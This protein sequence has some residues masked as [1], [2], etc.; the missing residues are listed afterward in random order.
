MKNKKLGKILLCTTLALATPFAL[1]ACSK[2]A[3]ENNTPDNNEPEIQQPV[4]S[5]VKIAYAKDFEGAN[6]NNT[7]IKSYTEVS[8]VKDDLCLVV[9]GEADHSK[10]YIVTDGQKYPVTGEGA[11]PAGYGQGVW[12][13]V[14]QDVDSMLGDGSAI[15]LNESHKY[16]ITVDKGIETAFNNYVKLYSD[17]TQVWQSMEPYFN[18]AVGVYFTTSDDR[19]VMMDVSYNET[20]NKIYIT[21]LSFTGHAMATVLQN[22]Q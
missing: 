11:Y 21:V 3:A 14:M 8:A 1:T 5:D 22:M 10:E 6:T 12:D 7:T 13:N 19:D 17:D 16:V 15:K 4:V 18:G 20:E 2:K 9:L